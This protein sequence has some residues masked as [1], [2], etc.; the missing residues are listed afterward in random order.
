MERGVPCEGADTDVDV[1]VALGLDSAEPV[2]RWT[3]VDGVLRSGVS[4]AE[5][6]VH[7]LHVH[8]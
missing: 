1:D 6:H 5:R 3:V 2:S 4:T 7:W 8:G